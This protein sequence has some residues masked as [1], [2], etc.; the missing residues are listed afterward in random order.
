MHNVV[1]FLDS[2]G[3]T[4]LSSLLFNK[5]SDFRNSVGQTQSDLVHEGEQLRERV[6]KLEYQI[7]M[8]N[9]VIASCKMATDERELTKL[10]VEYENMCR[11]DEPNGVV[12]E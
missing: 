11:K 1:P 8:A 7:I 9:T 2:I 4:S 12:Y 10:I 6:E 5:F 3:V